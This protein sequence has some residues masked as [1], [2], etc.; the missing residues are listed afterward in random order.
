MHCWIWFVVAWIA[1]EDCVSTQESYTDTNP[2]K[3]KYLAS[4]NKNQE[5]VQAHDINE[6][7][8]KCNTE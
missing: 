7:N 2:A 5:H 1:H 6:T 8:K 4:K 3:K